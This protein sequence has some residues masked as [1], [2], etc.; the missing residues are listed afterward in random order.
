[1]TSSC[2][3]VL[4]AKTNLGN[5]EKHCQSLATAT[6]VR[7]FSKTD[8]IPATIDS[9]ERPCS[10]RRY[11]C[12]PATEQNADGR[13]NFLNATGFSQDSARN[14]ATAPPRPPTTLCSSSV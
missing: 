14:S 3:P 10:A 4:Y 12:V 11:S 1:M 8:R 5:T 6:T 2:P 7:D 13:P 9:T